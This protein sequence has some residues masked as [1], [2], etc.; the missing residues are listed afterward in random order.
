[1]FFY[2]A[3][4][5]KPVVREDDRKRRQDIIILGQDVEVTRL[6]HHT[7]NLDDVLDNIRGTYSSDLPQHHVLFI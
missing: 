5:V 7:P 3:K 2:P 4:L 6:S 1:M